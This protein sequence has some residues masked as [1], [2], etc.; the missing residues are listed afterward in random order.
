M[1]RHNLVLFS[2][3]INISLWAPKHYKTRCYMAFFSRALLIPVFALLA[4]CN[5]SNTETLCQTW[6]YALLTMSITTQIEDHTA[7]GIHSQVLWHGPE[8]YGF[9]ENGER[10]AGSIQSNLNEFLKIDSISGPKMLNS[11]GSLGW[12]AYGVNHINQ[13]VESQSEAW[14]LKR[15]SD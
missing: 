5:Q 15:C 13:S 7:K 8:S 14:Y 11:L 9:W 4:S 6:E 2:R 10:L 1:G 3:Y 12:E